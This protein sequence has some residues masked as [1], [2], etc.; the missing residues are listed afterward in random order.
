MGDEIVLSDN[1]D[2]VY[3]DIN[4]L[5]KRK[6][7]E[8]KSTVNDAMIS[9]YWGIGK[10]LTEE[11]T[12]VNKPEYGQKV[13][14]EISNRLSVDY[15][16][17]F[18][19]SAISRMINFYQEFP[20][21]E[22]VATLS[23]QLTW[24]HFIEILPIKDELK[25]NFYAAMCKN[26]NWSVRTLRERKKSM[27]YERT[28]ISKKPDETIKN[29]IAELNEEKKMSVDM[30]YRDPYML[31]FLG[32][33]D[34]YSEKDLENAILA[35][36]EKFILEMGSDFAFLARQKHFVLDGKDYFMDLLFFHRTL[37][38]LVL[39]ELKLGE[40]E[41]QDKGQ[42]ELYLRWLEKYERAEGE[43]KPIALIL[44]AEKSQE[45]IELME[46]DNGSIHVAQYLTKMPP[47]EVLEKKLLQAIANAKE[48]LE[49]REE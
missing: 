29:E 5:I 26:E 27:L 38:R 8:V 9:L 24:S 49:Q 39:I 2:H 30:F 17:G 40:F 6:K 44:C 35:Q 16:T 1:F 18:N 3:D 12:G 45:T 33:K 37:R 48:Q 43:E 34:T 4:D 11:I 19:R 47:K 23:Q 32:L 25:R 42:V 22:K 41:P 10:K 7:C 36:L 31:D 28:A 15:G 21:Y 20:D 14:I 46:L 13:V